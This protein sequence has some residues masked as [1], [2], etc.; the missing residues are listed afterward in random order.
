RL[1]RPG[2]TDADGHV[3]VAKGLD[4]PPLTVGPRAE[5]LAAVHHRQVLRADPL[6]PGPDHFEDRF[7]VLVRE[8][9]VGPQDRT[10]LPEGPL[11]LA[12]G[13]LRAVDLDGVPAGHHPHPEGVA[14]ELQELVAV[15]EE[16]DGF[17]P[18]VE[19]EGARGGVRHAREG[20]WVRR[21]ETDARP[22]RRVLSILGKR[23]AGLRA[24]KKG[25]PGT[26]WTTPKRLGKRW[27]PM[28]IDYTESPACRLPRGRP[29]SAELRRDL[30]VS[31]GT[32]LS[33]PVCGTF[34]SAAGSK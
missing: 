32:V 23:G 29:A 21:S 10:H 6:R 30:S 11:G 31:A 8:L 22:G 34:L 9:A 7:H 17:V 1:A 33:R 16:E 12:D 19:R 24:Q 13:L 26:P 25:R 3:V 14:N 15:T 27:C 5:V 4:V 28:G 18:A 20:P 2:R